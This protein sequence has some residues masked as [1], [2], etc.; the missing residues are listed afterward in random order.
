V[1]YGVGDGAFNGPLFY[2]AAPNVWAIVVGQFNT[3]NLPD[4][5]VT[6]PGKDGVAV[7]INNGPN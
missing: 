6:V 3:D 7:L 2:S 4:I 1:L 5:A